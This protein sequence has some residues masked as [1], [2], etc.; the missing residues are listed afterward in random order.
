MYTCHATLNLLIF[1]GFCLQHDKSIEWSIFSQAK[2]PFPYFQCY[3]E[4][5]ALS[6]AYFCPPPLPLPFHFKLYQISSDSTLVVI[7]WFTS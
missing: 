4:N 2:F 6:T 5:S 1:T 7:K 3:L